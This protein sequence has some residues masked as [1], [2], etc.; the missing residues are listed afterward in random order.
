MTSSATRNNALTSRLALSLLLV[1]LTVGCQKTGKLSPELQ[2]RF[3][4][5][6][7][8]HRADDLIFRLYARRRPA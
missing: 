1:F 4:K 2:A 8:T 7:I 5:E 6:G 3:D